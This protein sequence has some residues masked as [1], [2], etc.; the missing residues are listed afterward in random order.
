MS[1]AEISCG[2]AYGFLTSQLYPENVPVFTTPNHYSGGL[3]QDRWAALLLPIKLFS[4]D[5]CGSVS[6]LNV[7]WESQP[8]HCRKLVFGRQLVPAYIAL[9][10]WQMPQ[11]TQVLRPCLYPTAEESPHPSWGA[12]SWRGPFSEEGDTLQG[13]Q[14]SR[15]QGLDSKRRT[16]LLGLKELLSP[17][18]A[19]NASFFQVLISSFA[20][21]FWISVQYTMLK[22]P[23]RTP[24]STLFFSAFCP[25]QLFCILWRTSF[26]SFCYF[27]YSCNANL[28][29]LL[30]I[31]LFKK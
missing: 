16:L 15:M 31:F 27:E 22:L 8:A 10:T 6:F 13:P 3:T 19:L 30:F 11:R 7:S 5:V 24:P 12:S 29:S 20:I 25:C 28:F 4:P 23:L 26:L 14:A 17:A 2:K 18:A 9:G 21:W 1:L